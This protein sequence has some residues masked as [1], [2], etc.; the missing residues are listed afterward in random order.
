M[1]IRYEQMEQYDL[2]SLDTP[3]YVD[4]AH[5]RSGGHTDESVEIIR[6]A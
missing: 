2:H 5:F 1:S 6:S 4:T 3:M